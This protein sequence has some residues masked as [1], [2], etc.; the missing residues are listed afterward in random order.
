LISSV[1]K[2]FKCLALTTG[3]VLVRAE[4]WLEGEWKEAEGEVERY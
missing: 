4:P 1:A 2:G 3:T